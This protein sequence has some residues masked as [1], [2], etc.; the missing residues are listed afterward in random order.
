MT[1]LVIVGLFP[2]AAYRVPMPMDQMARLYSRWP[3]VTVYYLDPNW[4]ASP[5][6]LWRHAT[7][8][9]A[10]AHCWRLWPLSEGDGEGSA[11]AAGP[12]FLDV[13]G[14]AVSPAELLAALDAAERVVVGAHSFWPQLSRRV[15]LTLLP[16]AVYYDCHETVVAMGG[17][18]DWAAH[19]WLV[20][21]ADAVLAISPLVAEAV[22]A[23]GRE[24]LLLGNGI[25]GRRFAAAPP[26]PPAWTF[27]F[28]GSFYDWVDVPALQALAA[29]CPNETIVLM[30]PVHES[31]GQAYAELTALPNVI[32][33]PGVAYGDVPATLQQIE[34]C[35]LPRLLTPDSMACDPLKLYEY[36]AAGRPAAS[37]RLPAAEALAGAVYLAEGGAL[38]AAEAQ[39]ALADVRAGRFDPAPGR[40]A[41]AGRTW[42]ARCVAVWDALGLPG[43]TGARAAA[44]GDLGRLHS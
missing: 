14:R 27:G 6:L 30:G 20:A 24:P 1:L 41:V 43:T 35:L 16:D 15:A 2:W 11:S 33:H 13:E 26:A 8:G 18:P 34:V 36:L 10:A 5:G 9:R 42:E 17:G 28:V 21:R 4:P 19:Q 23:L 22:R 38:F 3:D 39:R 7:E 37:T 12:V 29:A 44:S 40:L 31:M 25:D 32:A